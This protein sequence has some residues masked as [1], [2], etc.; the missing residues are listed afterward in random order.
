[1]EDRAEW[2]Q[3]QT[4]ALIKDLETTVERY[5]LAL[6][7]ITEFPLDSLCTLTPNQLDLSVRVIVLLAKSALEAD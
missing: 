2:E 6:K 7:R 4:E 5:E 3:L 1:M